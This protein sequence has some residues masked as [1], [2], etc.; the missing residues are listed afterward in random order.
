MLLDLA[1]I[2]CKTNTSLS[3]HALGMMFMQKS[4][5]VNTEALKK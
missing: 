5:T 1:Q 4:S 2:I 3:W